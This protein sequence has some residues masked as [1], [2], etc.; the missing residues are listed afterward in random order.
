MNGFTNM[1]PAMATVVAAIVAATVAMLSLLISKENKISEFRQGWVDALREDLSE[2]LALLVHTLGVSAIKRGESVEAAKQYL[3]QNEAAM[4]RIGILK[5]RI[6]LRLNSTEHK[7]LIDLLKYSDNS[8]GIE[9]LT[10][11]V[12]VSEY[13]KQFTTESARVLKYEWS[14]VKRG[15]TFFNVAKWSSLLAIIL[16]ISLALYIRSNSTPEAPNPSMHS[17]PT[18]TRSGR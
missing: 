4:L 10:N 8:S 9:I 12:H 15:E 13:M 1:N 18:A 7:R 6:R 5:F 16:L 11:P 2:Y 17:D 14:R 3:E